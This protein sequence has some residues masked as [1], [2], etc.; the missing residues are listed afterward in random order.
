VI[1]KMAGDRLMEQS[2]AADKGIRLCGNIN[3]A[4][5]T[6]NDLLE[7]E[8]MELQL[9]AMKGWL[10]KD[11]VVTEKLLQQS[12]AL[13]QKVGYSYG[14]PA[15]VKPTYEM[16][17]EWLLETGKPKQALEQFELSL[18]LAPNRLLS[19]KGKEK[20]REELKNTKLEVL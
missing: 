6:K 17:G 16:Y 7:S 20:A 14:P 15:I 12:T 9:K 3:R 5:V 19:L 8:A 1:T 13:Q 11:A 4:I 18:K 2:K 10:Q